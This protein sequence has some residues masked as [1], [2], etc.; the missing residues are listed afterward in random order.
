MSATARPPEGGAPSLGEVVAQRPEGRPANGDRLST[1]VQQA[2]AQGL[3]PAGAEPPVVET[4]PWPVMLL[5]A[6]GAWLAAVPLIGVVGMLLG[7]LVS[8]GAGPYLIGPLVL[9]VAVTVLRAREVPL[10]VEQLAVPALL[11]GGGALAMGLFRDLPP[12]AGAAVLA[13]I[14]LGLAHALP[15]PWLRVLLGAGAA[16]A[17]IMASLPERAPDLDRG[18]VAFGI[19]CLVSFAVWIAGLAL[20]RRARHDVRLAAFAATLEPVSAGWLLAVLV[21]LAGWSGMT[22]LVGASAGGGFV[23]AVAGE[24]MRAPKPAPAF[25]ALQAASLMLAAVAAARLALAWPAVRQPWCGGVAAIGLVLAWFMPALGAVLLAMAL[26]AVDHRG[27]LAAACALGAAWIVGAFYYQL[28]WPLA[29]KALVL[30]AAG[31]WLGAMARW[32][33]TREAA[34]SNT[35][36]TPRATR[37][38]RVA[39]ALAALAT[40]V[41]VNT[42][43]W[44]K[45]QLIAQGRPV[46]IELAPVDPRSLMQGDY[47]RLDFRVPDATHDGVV[48]GPRPRVVARADPRGIATLLRLD[49]GTPLAPHELAI[50]LTPKNGRWTVV[51]DAWYFREGE[52]ARWAKAKYGEFRVDAQG[53]ALLV[54]LRGPQLDHL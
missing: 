6:L 36:T 50:E 52:A 15:R 4:R 19:A 17:A 29:T 33:W 18:H 26:C 34:A 28:A 54:G 3:L 20:Q 53:R 14:A 49:T 13:L 38:A 47:M 7:D 40:V 5:T 27:R 39:I 21:G 2:T 35:A 51:T 44:R 24:L 9:A 43:I 30:V 1:L 16:A 42:G 12:R 31:A 10:F 11:V 45:Q 22:F 25:T 48:A 46:F 8:R 37:V 32:G 23:G 41:V